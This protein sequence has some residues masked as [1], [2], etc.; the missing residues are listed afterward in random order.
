MQN[1]A[2]LMKPLFIKPVNFI[3]LFDSKAKTA[4]IET[5]NQVRNMRFRL[6]HHK[7]FKIM[8]IF[9]SNSA[10]SGNPLPEIF[11]TGDISNEYASYFSINSLQK[12]LGRPFSLHSM[13]GWLDVHLDFQSKQLSAETIANTLIL[14]EGG[15]LKQW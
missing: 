4:L 5:I 8:D 13:V 7:R 15:S 14:P 6:P 12:W 2:E 11:L 3:K 9:K 1:V 10:G